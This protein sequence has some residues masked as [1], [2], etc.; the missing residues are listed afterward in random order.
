MGERPYVL[1]S[2]AMSVDGYIDDNTPHRL[3]LS[4]DEDFDR[5]DAVRATCDAILVGAGTVRRDDPRLLVRSPERGRERAARGLPPSPAKVTLT[6]TG[7]LD[8]GAAFFTAGDAE[9][10]VYA[11]PAAVAKLADRLGGA[12]EVVDAGGPADPGGPG[13]LGGPGSQ[14]DPAGP[15]DA[16]GDGG[17]GRDG[18]DLGRVLSDLYGRG[19]R[20]LMVEGGTSVHTRFLREDLVDELH[21]VVAPFFVGDPAA[22]RFVLGG[23]FPRDRRR[24]MNLAET[25]AM[26]DV[27]LLRYLLS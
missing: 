5:V 10:I 8:P 7:D 6:A 12:A 17:D 24:R 14:V 11:A 4:N 25:R 18:V 27:T 16:G 3:L 2:C 22:P 1:L 13:D 15:G 20:R 19:V 9:R 26:G 23:D 21:L